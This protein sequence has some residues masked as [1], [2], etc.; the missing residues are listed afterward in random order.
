MRTGL[1]LLPLLRDQET[2]L[3]DLLG[4]L[5]ETNFHVIL[6]RTPTILYHRIFDKASRVAITYRSIK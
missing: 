1:E 4:P 3:T 5:I 2:K 6:I